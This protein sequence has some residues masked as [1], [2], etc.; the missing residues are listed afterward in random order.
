MDNEKTQQ[1]LVALRSGSDL[2]TACHFAALSIGAVYRWLERG[3]IEAERIENGFDADPAESDMLAFWDD[4]KKAR[5]DAVMRNVAH[6]QRA[7]SDGEWRAAT[8]WLERA[9]PDVY[10]NAKTTKKLDGDSSKE[11]PS[12]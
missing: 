5:A 3:K 4:I 11:L 1:L 9:V 8:W 2:Q 12:A 10:G 7:A 6:V